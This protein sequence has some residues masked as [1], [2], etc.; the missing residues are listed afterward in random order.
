MYGSVENV[1]LYYNQKLWFRDHPPSRNHNRFSQSASGPCGALKFRKGDVTMRIPTHSRNRKIIWIMLIMMIMCS[2]TGCAMVQPVNAV[3]ETTPA[4]DYKNAYHELL[5]DYNAL[6]V[7]H[8][9]LLAS[10]G[11]TVDPGFQSQIDALNQELTG[12]RDELTRTQLERDTA[13]AE[14]DDLR[15]ENG[16]KYVVELEVRR[17]VLFPASE[18]CLRIKI[19]VSREEFSR[20]QKGSEV[21][22]TLSQ[23]S[24]PGD[25]I[26]VDW[27]IT[28]WDA[29]IME[30][31]PEE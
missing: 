29:Y 1:G 27:T 31:P 3:Q 10:S 23:L 9:E 5:E 2:T 21:T 13:M 4:E 14:A 17:K 28:V 15:R 18:E 16:K 6:L 20:F 22:Q 7:E 19:P 11:E 26:N 25:S 8:N 12:I 24:I 30:Q